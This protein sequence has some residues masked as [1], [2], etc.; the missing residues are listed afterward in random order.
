MQVSPLSGNAA[1]LAQ[2]QPT[3]KPAG[4]TLSSDF[5][6]FLKMLTAQMKNQDPLNPIDSS[7]Y[8]TQLATF[9]SVEQQVV[10][11]DLLRSLGGQMGIMGMSQLA[12][13]VGMEARAD[14]PA[15]FDGTPISLSLRPDHLA[16]QTFLIVRDIDG[17]IVERTELPPSTLSAEWAGTN[18]DGTPFDEA[19]Y[20][21]E[22]ESLSQG[23]VLNTRSVESYAQIIEARNTPAGIVL[24]ME[25][26]I[27][28][29]SGSISA[30]RSPL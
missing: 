17:N 4:T 25:G 6:T 28:I 16:D 26:G 13:W 24:V 30:I 14:A 8:A 9:S 27:E 5:E 11:N 29:S 18:A 21:F 10:T 19:V 12:S 23:N 20:F 3:I 7:D 22:L 15:Y 2:N 1:Q